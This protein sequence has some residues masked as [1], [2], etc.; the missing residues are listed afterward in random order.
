MFKTEIFFDEESANRFIRKLQDS[1]LP[2]EISYEDYWQL[3]ER[4]DCI[5]IYY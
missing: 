1:G 5:V 4:I 2:Y 3:D